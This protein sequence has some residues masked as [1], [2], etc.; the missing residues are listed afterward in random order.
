MEIRERQPCSRYKYSFD[1][2]DWLNLE[3][4]VP[5]SVPP[6]IVEASRGPTLQLSIQDC[7]PPRPTIW[8]KNASLLLTLRIRRR[9]TRPA[10]KYKGQKKNGRRKV[11]GYHAGERIKSR[12]RIPTHLN[13]LP[14]GTGPPADFV[15]GDMKSSKLKRLG[16]VARLIPS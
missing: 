8:S 2:L 12:R 16:I 7:T 13:A 11:V 4:R 1:Q 15:R 10:A 5:M 3:S 14:H 6:M 9:N